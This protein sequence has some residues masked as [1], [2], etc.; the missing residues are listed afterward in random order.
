[1]KEGVAIHKYI[2]VSPKKLRRIANAFKKKNVGEV[3]A[4]AKVLPSYSVTPLLKAI[5]SAAHNLKNKLEEMK[6][7]EELWVEDIRID[8]GF[9]FKRIKPRARGRADIIRK[10][11]SHIR[12][13]VKESK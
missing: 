11:T 10:R 13:V 4:I 8:K 3:I 1:M 2:R 9:T 7:I 5:L 6:E 12:V